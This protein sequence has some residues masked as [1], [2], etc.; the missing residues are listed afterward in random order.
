MIMGY[1]FAST[2]SPASRRS[3]LSFICLGILLLAGCRGVS[4]QLTS[5]SV[6]TAGCPRFI[7][8]GP[9]GT[10]WFTDLGPQATDGQIANGQLPR[11][12]I[13]RFTLSG[14]I[15]EFPLPDSSTEVTGLTAG[16]DGN[17]WFTD[18]MNDRIGR[19]TPHGQLT[20][21]SMPST[22]S[23]SD[24]YPNDI[25]AGPEMSLWF[26][27][28]N[29]GGPDHLGRITQDGDITTF[30]VPNTHAFDDPQDITV[31]PDGNLWFT[32]EDGRIVRMTPQGKMT[33]F[34]LPANIVPDEIIVGPDRNLWFTEVKRDQIGRI[35]PQG[36]IIELPFP[37]GKS[38]F[39]SIITGPDGNLWFMDRTVV[40]R[41][42]LQGQITTFSLPLKEIPGYT[43]K[44][45]GI[46]TGP[47]GNL[48]ITI[49]SDAGL[50]AM[51]RLTP[52]GQFTMV[53]PPL[54][55]DNGA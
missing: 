39:V 22:S 1:I 53:F 41:L 21:F 10:L 11:E 38:D 16:P 43:Y 20:E 27:L 2:C 54:A 7:T 17:L 37:N 52:H 36:R 35:T 33:T 15:T 45:T 18:D 23:S 44:A 42:T 49:G 26:L 40:G 3:L 34:S 47:D 25:I 6:S 50:C 55:A 4:H 5:V 12:R 30:P 48:W 29:E 8:T 31:G 32:V 51:G 46:T 13:G 28:L 14:Q 19:L 9:G 24:D